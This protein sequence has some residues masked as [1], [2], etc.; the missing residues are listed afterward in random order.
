MPKHLSKNVISFASILEENTA[1]QAITS[2]KLPFIFPH[3]ALMPDAHLGYGA[4]V[5]SVIPT[6]GA[7]IP[8]AV[9]VD[10]GCGMGALSTNL[11]VED[12]E[13]KD[14][15][16]LRASIEAAIPLSPGRYNQK[17]E[18]DAQRHVTFLEEH[19]KALDV[20]PEEFAENWRLQLG[21]L[22][23]G[24]HFIEVSR[25]ELGRVWIFLHSGS[26]GVG[27]KIARKYMQ[28]AKDQCEARF[29]DLPEQ[30]LAYLVEGEP[31]FRQYLSHLHWAQEF[32]LRNRQVMLDRVRACLADWHGAPVE[33]EDVILCH[34]N[35]T[36]QEN[37]FGKNVWLT[38]KG[39]INASEGTLGLIPGSMGTRSY[40]VRG[41]G[42]AL[43]L[44]SA[45]HGAGRRYSRRAARERFT[46]EDLRA[47]MEGIEYRDDPAF[48]DEIPDAYKPIGQVMEDSEDLV[49]VLHELSQLVNVKGE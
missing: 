7:I 25:D 17:V 18:E 24:N 31:E 33:I 47:R 37:H 42:N 11:T 40:V 6:R 5:G 32:A 29:I 39:A 20:H 2:G 26:R 19:A 44:N 22:G 1:E 34:H 41:K 23:G 35:Y 12:L 4:T 48:I 9:G 38:R 16:A 45:P 10:I 46:Q 30:D 15:A 27:N 3:I 49:E 36:A 13:G 8:G 28:I 21:S 14:L 43:A